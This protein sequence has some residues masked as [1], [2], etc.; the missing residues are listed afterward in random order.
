[1]KTRGRCSPGGRQYAALR[2]GAEPRPQPGQRLQQPDRRRAGT[3]RRRVRLA[4]LFQQ[5]RTERLFRSGQRHR[6]PA[7][8]RW[9]TS[10]R[11]ARTFP[12]PTTAAKPAATEPA[13]SVRPNGP[14]GG[15]DWY[16]RNVTGTSF[17]AP[18]VAGGAALL[19]DAAYAAVRRNPDARDAR[20]MKA[21]LMNSADKTLGWNNGQI[22]HPN[23]NG[24]VLT[25]QGLDN[26]VGAGRMNLDRGLRPI[27]Q[28][29]DRRRRHRRRAIGRCRKHRLGF[30]PG[31][32][33]R[34]ERLLPDRRCSPAGSNVHR[35]ARLVPRSAQRSAPPTSPTTAT[36]IWTW[37][38]GKRSAAWPSTDLRIQQ[39]LQQH[40]TLQLRDPHRP[41]EYM[42]R[43]RWTGEIFDLVGDANSEQYGLA[44]SVAVPEPGTI[45]LLALVACCG[46]FFRRSR[47]MVA[48]DRV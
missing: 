39:P 44:W 35:H 38:C 27:A 6:Q 48:Q 21:V 23:G 11:P 29:H 42:L 28:R 24:G 4:E 22:A 15:P 47:K 1:M 19:Y 31:G 7:P 41:A 16:S 37:N 43:V 34:H 8:G 46:I 30:R 45:V 26:R 12:P 2:R 33:R 10:R 14:A 40:R 5:R 20:V 36:T 25:T 3:E 17:S 13:C 32:P 18:T 9:S